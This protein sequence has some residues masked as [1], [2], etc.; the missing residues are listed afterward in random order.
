MKVFETRKNWPRFH[1]FSNIVF[2]LLVTRLEDKE[3]EIR[4][5]HFIMLQ[6]LGKRMKKFYKYDYCK[7]EN[8]VQNFR[9]ASELIKQINPKTVTPSRGKFF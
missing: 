1:H 6:S 4:Y 3:A 5:A 2:I 8:R 7:N 9:K